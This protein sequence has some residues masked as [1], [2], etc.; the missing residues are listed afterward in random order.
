MRTTAIGTLILFVAAI[1]ACN[2]FDFGGIRDRFKENMNGSL[3]NPGSIDPAG[4]DSFTFAVMGDSHTGVPWGKVL[5]SAVLH[6][7]A[8]GDAFVILAGDVTNF[9]KEDEFAELL[10]VFSD[11]G[12]TFRATL[13][14]HDLYFEG[15]KSYAKYLGRS[16]YSF[17]ADNVHFSMLDSGNAILGEAQLNW[18]RTDL[19]STTKPIKIVVSHYPAISA[20]FDTLYKMASEEESAILKN[21]LNKYQV[22][23]MFAGHYHGY[24]TKQLGYTNHVVTGGI[25]TILDPGNEKHYI[26]VTINGN[27]VSAQK[28]DL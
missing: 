5:P 3:S 18:L 22:N 4:T 8:A 9:G 17:D 14:N 24:R 23:Y 28:I 19:E 20:D 7:Q 16:I 11:L 1:V 15:W 2:N 25:N 26:R 21:L 13:G 12:V 27:T 10:K 6:S